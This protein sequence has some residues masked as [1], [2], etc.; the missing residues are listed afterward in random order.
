MPEGK[1]TEAQLCGTRKP[2][3]KTF[4]LLIFNT[5][6]S[7]FGG[8][9]LC[10]VSPQL[11][12]SDGLLIGRRMGIE[13]S[14]EFSFVVWGTIT[15]PHLLMFYKISSLC[16]ITFPHHVPLMGF[17]HSTSCKK[18]PLFCTISNNPNNNFNVTIMIVNFSVVVIDMCLLAWCARH[19]IIHST[20]C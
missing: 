2:P 12:G 18:R 1:R 17:S 13:D 4:P 6:P 3:P 14:Y 9:G 7:F 8:F 16:S 19:V 5:P 15:C 11:R 20:L 10:W